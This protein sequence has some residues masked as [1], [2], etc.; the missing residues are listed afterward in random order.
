MLFYRRDKRQGVPNLTVAASV[1]VRRGG[2]MD[3]GGHDR[4][5]CNALQQQID[6]LDKTRKE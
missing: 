4:F 1:P 2:A 3:K 5:V 6:A